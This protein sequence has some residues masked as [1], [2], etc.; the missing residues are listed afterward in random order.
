VTGQRQALL[1]EG[2]LAGRGKRDFLFDKRPSGV[3]CCDVVTGAG[4]KRPIAH[5]ISFQES[6][7][8]D[9]KRAV[10]PAAGRGTRMRPLSDRI[11]KELLPLG[12]KL[13]MDHALEEAVRS[14]VEQVC[15]VISPQKE[16]IQER[17]TGDRKDLIRKLGHI[18][19][20][21]NIVFVTQE[22]PLGLGD[23]IAAARDFVAG[24]PFGVLLPD[25]VF[26]ADVAP[27]AQLMKLFS[28]HR[29]PCVG[30]MEVPENRA[31][32]YSSARK[33]L[34]RR[35]S[36]GVYNNGVHKDDA[37]A[38]DVPQ[39]DLLHNGAYRIEGILD[40][41]PGPVQTGQIRSIGRYILTP[42][43]FDFYAS[44]R[45]KIGGEL[46]ETDVLKEF[47]RAGNELYGLLLEGERF[48]TGT[49]DGYAH[50]FMSFLDRGL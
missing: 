21:M 40:D 14:G 16:S 17:Y 25:N 32:F 6:A 42:R 23:A 24:Q 35:V 49:I 2:G 36:E 41:D 12:R 30:L 34:Y 38:D 37:P 3:Y 13:V 46:R 45:K 15:I 19:N 22:R 26:L 20:F 47:L 29:A 31:V 1:R 11:P 44:A 8:M 27:L 4:E 28:E 18:I 50:A 5:I 7:K 43:Y 48:D 9:V 33:L 10:I 39:D